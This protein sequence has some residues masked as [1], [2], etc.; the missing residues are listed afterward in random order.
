MENYETN[1]HQLDLVQFENKHSFESIK[2]NHRFKIIY[3]SL[4]RPTEIDSEGSSITKCYYDREGDLILTVKQ[5]YDGMH[6]TV[7]SVIRKIEIDSE[8]NKVLLVEDYA[9]GSMYNVFPKPFSA[10]L[11]IPSQ[12]IKKSNE[13][14]P[15]IGLNDDNLLNEYVSIQ[16][17]D[18]FTYLNL[19]ILG[20]FY[21]PE[22]NDEPDD[23][24]DLIENMQ[25]KLIEA[26]YSSLYLLDLKIP[27]MQIN[28][29]KLPDPFGVLK[30]D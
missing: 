14:H 9:K 7:F 13:L 11:L 26:G 4:E 12:P 20:D 30:Q 25:P 28:P 6:H 1:S 5:Y 27:A 24:E 15:A 29:E 16:H 10:S 21:V 22:D 19:D 23:I 8:G 18:T 3:D 2:R 17:D